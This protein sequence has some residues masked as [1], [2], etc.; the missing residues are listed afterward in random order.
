MIITV[1][2]NPALDRTLTVPQ[3]VFD[4]MVRASDSRLDLDGKGVNVSKALGQLGLST[5]LLGFAGGATGEMLE[6]RLREQGFATDFTRVAGETRTNTMILDATNTRYVKANEPGPTLRPAELA[7]FF[8]QARAR[9]AP[10]DTWILSGSLPPGTPDGFYAEL[11]SLIQSG[12]ARALLDTSG[13]PLRLGCA[14]R[15]YL[16]KPNAGEAQALTGEPI[17]G[18][19]TV[20]RAALYFLD[21]GVELVALSLGADGL[22]LAA[23][24]QAAR[25]RPPRVHALNP[26]GAGDALLAGIAWALEQRLDLAELARWGVASGTAAAMRA[27]TDSAARS[28]VEALHAQVQVERWQ[29][30]GDR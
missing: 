18:E 16:A 12:G 29:L 19:A 14:A 4:E 26:V 21:R 13:E 23:R 7:T 5:L 2:P 15:P 20:R 6:R 17:D 24:D 22:L 8:S 10:G 1:T 11:V 30:R 27:G 28:A 9:L 3:I 25:A